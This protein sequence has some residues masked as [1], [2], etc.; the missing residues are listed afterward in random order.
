MKLCSENLKIR[1]LLEDL[2]INGKTISKCITM[3]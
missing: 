1:R 3:S 2:G